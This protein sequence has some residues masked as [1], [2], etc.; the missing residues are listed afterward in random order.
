MLSIDRYLEELLFQLR[1]QFQDR[2][3]YVGLQGSYSRGEADSDS[4]IDIMVVLDRLFASD[5]AVYR[6]LIQSLQDS[7]QSCGFICGCQEL[8]NWNPC[9][10]CQLVHETHDYYGILQPLLPAYTPQDIRTQIQ[11]LT[12]NL[13]HEICHRSIHASTEKSVQ[14]LPASY[15][16]VFY[17]LQNLYFLQ[18]GQWI[19]SK[20]ELVKAL[21]APDATILQRAITLRR[22]PDCCN[23][24]Q[25]FPLL[26]DW[27]Q[28]ILQTASF[29]GKTFSDQS[30][31]AL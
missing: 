12:G 22:S 31:D 19:P 10:I 9:E 15:Q 30:S 24:D 29:L 3:R 1:E 14:A 20:Q 18:N 8:Q 13:Y 16:S 2:L 17:I 7:R 11:I 23:F 26:F 21:S 27:C 25:D 28:H 6:S 4:D 5:L